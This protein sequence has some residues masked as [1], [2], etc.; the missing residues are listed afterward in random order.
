[1]AFL[2]FS[3]SA[4]SVASIG[5][6][7]IE[8]ANRPSGECLRGFGGDTLNTAVYLARLGQKAS[9]VTKLG[10]DPYSQQML[11]AWQAEGVDTALVRQVPGRVPGLYMITTD[12]AGERSFSYWRDRSPARELFSPLDPA[13]EAAL[14]DKDIIYLSGISLSL[15]DAAGL[16]KL[17]ALLDHFR[18]TGGQVVFDGNYRPAGW[19]DKDLARQVFG[20][21]LARTDLAL[22]TH[23]DEVAL[24]GDASLEATLTRLH[25]AG[26]KE[27]GV[28]QGAEGCVLSDGSGAVQVVAALPGITAVDTTAAGDSFN[29]GYLAGRLSGQ[30]PT[31]AAEQAHKVAS[32]V[33][34]HPGAIIP[35]SVPLV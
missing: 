27:V 34:T 21:M 23:D 17:M 12:E 3:S 24:F 25:D 22:P 8:I 6:C 1:M 20:R 26:V 5:E 19:P 13:T 32:R 9:Y 28:K 35:A 31:E 16:D 4:A 18:A 29:A 14:L 7:M 33:I 2:T 10:D 30:A 11:S 15:Y